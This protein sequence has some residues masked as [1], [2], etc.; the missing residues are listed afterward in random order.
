MKP[1]L[2]VKGMNKRYF[3][4]FI[5]LQWMIYGGLQALFIFFL[6]AFSFEKRSLNPSGQTASFWVVGMIIYGSIVMLVNFE[7]LYQTNT[8]SVF[9]LALVFGSIALYYG[10]YVIENY[11][12]FVPVLRGTFYYLWA[13]TQYYFVLFF[14]IVTQWMMRMSIRWTRKAVKNFKRKRQA[15]TQ[16]QH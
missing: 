13:T 3:G 6:T 9:S 4:K 2:Y 12:D 7:I 5:F 11:L 1:K 8:H 16:V 10:I 14:L 15:I